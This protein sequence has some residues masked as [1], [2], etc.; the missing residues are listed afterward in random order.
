MLERHHSVRCSAYLKI[1]FKHEDCQ[2]LYKDLFHVKSWLRKCGSR[3]RERRF[4]LNLVLKNVV[5]IFKEKSDLLQNICAEILWF[6]WSLV[7][8]VHHTHLASILYKQRQKT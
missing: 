2:I 5:E 1:C 4:I 7:G 8:F 3:R 6:S